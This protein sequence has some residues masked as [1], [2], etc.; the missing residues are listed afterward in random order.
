MSQFFK[1]TLCP[2]HTTGGSS[3]GYRQHGRKKRE[4]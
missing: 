2:S 3:G 4:V 1:D